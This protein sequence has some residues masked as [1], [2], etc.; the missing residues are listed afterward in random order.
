MKIKSSYEEEYKLA[1]KNAVNV[2][3]MGG[4]VKREEAVKLW[5]KVK[6]WKFLG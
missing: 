2:L 5:N 1:L 4:I 3:Y 6:K